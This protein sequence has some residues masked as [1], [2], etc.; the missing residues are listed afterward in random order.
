VTLPT[1]LRRR[2]EAGLGPV[3]DAR[4][5]GGGSISRALRV[6]LA[7]GPAFLKYNEGGPPGMFAAEAR[8]LDA[9]R[10]AAPDGLRV[11]EVRAVL[12]PAE[13][14]APGEPGWI[15]L[16]WI[17]PGARGP[18][19]GERLGRG[20]A[21]L[22][23][24]T[25]GRIG[26]DEDNFI[27]TL[28][29][30]NAETATWAEF[31]RERRLEPLLRRARD[32]GHAPGE[33]R[34]WERL[35]AGLDGL[36]APGDEIVPSL[37]HGDLWSGNVLASASGEPCLVDPAVYLGHREVDLAM[38]DLF[39]GF[40]P[41]FHEAYAEVWPLLPGYREARRAAYQL[42]YLL[43]HVVLFGGGYAAQTRAA[44]REALAAL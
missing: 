1:A 44:L 6:E 29:Q 9:L 26:W 5:V 10:H 13:E 24:G 8:G 40:P 37:L 3:R 35:F 33:A 27:A 12:D 11:P 18:G 36:L 31:W 17:E 42:Y 41:G 32:A 39:G 14:G 23:R 16:E 7:G 22:H 2:L 15:L 38:A 28:P 21:L 25:E 19:F 43:V 30:P 34:E 20:L 4:P